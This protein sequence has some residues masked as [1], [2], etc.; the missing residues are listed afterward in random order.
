MASSAS[1]E[2]RKREPTTKILRKGAGQIF[3]RI[4]R[5]G[6]GQMALPMSIRN[7]PNLRKGTG[8][9]RILRKGTGILR[10]GTGQMSL[11]MSIRNIP[12]GDRSIG[13][14][15]LL[16]EIAPSA[17]ALVLIVGCRPCRYFLGWHHPHPKR[18]RAQRR[19]FVRLLPLGFR[20][21]FPPCKHGKSSNE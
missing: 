9:K 7:I 19:R 21:S 11:P 6:T 3:E 14:M 16:T 2:I 8:Q 5:K 1:K 18:S 20:D 15:S 17:I 4:L 10:K 13:R 12:K